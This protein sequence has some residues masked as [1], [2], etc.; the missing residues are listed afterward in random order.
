MLLKRA[1]LTLQKLN[2]FI[3]IMLQACAILSLNQYL[4]ADVTNNDY[5][6]N[7]I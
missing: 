2:I 1:G 3:V 6:N 4:N 5:K 7:M